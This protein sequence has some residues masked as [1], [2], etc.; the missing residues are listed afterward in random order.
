MSPTVDGREMYDPE[1]LPP[2]PRRR[3]RLDIRPKL[4]TVR[5]TLRADEVAFLDSVAKK[6]GR[7]RAK[8]LRAILRGGHANVLAEFYEDA[9]SAEIKQMNEKVR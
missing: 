4:K 2:S 7:T 1:E 9:V 8:I 5:I 6:E 3:M